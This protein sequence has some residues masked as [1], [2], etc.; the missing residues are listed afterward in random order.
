MSQDVKKQKRERI[1]TK[2]KEVETAVELKEDNRLENAN[3]PLEEFNWEEHEATCPSVT[4]K[5]NLNI[6]SRRGH[7]V[8]CR[9]PYAQ[10]LYD[11]MEAFDSGNETLFKLNEGE[12]H[13]G[14][15]NSIDTEWAS[16]D[17]GY[18][19][20]VYVDL[21]R[22]SDLSKSKMIPGEKIS[23][24][25]T[26]DTNGRKS[27]Y[28]KGSVE[29][30]VKAAV[31]RE[32]L[33]AIE[34]GNTAY[35]GNVT[36][37]IPGGGY[38][39]NVQGV[40]CFMPG[41]LA[42][43]NKLVDFESIIGEDMYVVPTNY[44]PERGTVIVSHRKYLQA[45]IPHKLEELNENLTK[46]R[47]GSV[48]GSAKYGVFVEFEGCLTGMIH[49]N[50]LTPEMLKKHIAREI[51][52]GD[53]IEFKVKE[54]ISQRKITLTQLEVVDVVDPW[55]LISKEF[56]KFP[57]E[58]TGKIKSVKDYGVFVDVFDGI[59]GLLHISE[60]PEGVTTDSMKKED[61]ITVQ[62]QRIEEDTRKVFLKL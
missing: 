36:S 28:V 60:L 40:D 30:G 26:G 53:S 35:V 59:V 13:E 1:A 7:K 16:I 46:L 54:V 45:M 11:I 24:Q 5:P 44:S 10:E 20:N 34:E 52:P 23:V 41:S 50:D 18:K 27:T 21:S 58:V 33:G 14:V 4:R 17:I 22:E 62:I 15:V 12:T 39:V 8:F 43:I 25:I 61:K 37:M 19:E 47:T 56:T 38:M 31:L 57:A 55:K 51:K 42:G 48:T 49:V 6:K 2:T 3:V 9:E 32:I 29:A